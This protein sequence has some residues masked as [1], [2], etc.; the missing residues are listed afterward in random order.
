MTKSKKLLSGF[1]L[2]FFVFTACLFGF[3]GCGG[4]T[5]EGVCITL[6]DFGVKQNEE[7]DYNNV[8]VSLI[9]SDKSEIQIDKGYE[10]VTTLDTTTI[11]R[12]EL[13]VKYVDDNKKSYF[14]STYVCVYGDFV[15]L[16]VNEKSYPKTVGKDI[17]FDISNLII[18]VEYECDENNFQKRLTLPNDFITITETDEEV[19]GIESKVLDINYNDGTVNANTSV[20]INYSGSE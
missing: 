14:G 13:K 2:G 18:Y 3:A 20:V 11:G 9:M 1:I 8:I 12:K 15:K 10:I 19:E 17:G 4:P 7:L 6:S 5:I 16:S